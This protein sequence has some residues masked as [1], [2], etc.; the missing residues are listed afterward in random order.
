M[1]TVTAGEVGTEARAAITEMTRGRVAGQA[2]ADYVVA[3]PMT[4]AELADGGWDQLGVP[5]AEGG[6]GA[7]VRDLVEVA[8][9]WGETLIP[10]PLI[11]TLLA[12]RWSEAARGHAGPVSYAVATPSTPGRFTVPFGAVEGLALLSG[13]DGSA[14]LHPRDALFDAEADDYA[15]SLRLVTSSASTE[16]TAASRAEA[17]VVWAAECTG[18]ATRVLRD[19][20]TY[21]TQRQQFGRPVGSFQAVKHHLADAH[22]L[23]QEAESAVIWGSLEPHRAHQASLLAMDNA[24][25]VIEIAIQ[26]H[27]GLGFTWEMGLH[28]FLRHTVALRDLALALRD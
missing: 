24:A 1:S 21:V 12:K 9:A 23:V 2:V 5:E 25:R 17:V 14:E 4:W 10:L 16:W 11:P 20:V 27:G 18:A 19:T 6:A 28:M 7:S 3:S 8:M 15:P 22:I 13:T 26:A